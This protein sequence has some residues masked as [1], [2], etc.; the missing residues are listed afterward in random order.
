MAGERDA[1]AWIQKLRLGNS[2][3]LLPKVSRKEMGDLFRRSMISVS[4]SVH[5]GT[6][7]TLLEGMACGCF[8][9]AGDIESVREWITSGRNGILVDPS[10]PIALATAILSALDQPE[11]RQRAGELNVKLV[12][13]R[14]EYYQVMQRAEQFYAQISR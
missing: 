13:E 5:D 9:I 10:D 7:N 12:A 8:P 2:V 3:E 14:A 1:E 11:F 4:P 6:P